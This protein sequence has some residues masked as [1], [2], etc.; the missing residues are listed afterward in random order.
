VGAHAHP[1]VPPTL[2]LTQLHCCRAAELAPLPCSLAPPPPV[3]HFA[4]AS[5]EAL[6]SQKEG[7]P[8][9]LAF[10][11]ALALASQFDGWPPAPGRLDGSKSKQGPALSGGAAGQA[12]GAH[13]HPGVPP[14]LP[15]TQLHCCRAAELAP[16]PCSLAPPPPVLHFALASAEALASQNE[17]DPTQLAFDSAL[18]LASQCDVPPPPGGTCMPPAPGTMEWAM[19]SLLGLTYWSGIECAGG[20]GG[21]PG[22]RTH[23]HR[24]HHLS[25]WHR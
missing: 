16:L 18:A 1:G 7:D 24:R 15:L 5:A 25:L 17:A 10:D 20:V 23:H 6:A 21:R 13:A 8:T 2:P 4:L 9:Q 14:T 3:L 12:V 19:S 22:R 11:S